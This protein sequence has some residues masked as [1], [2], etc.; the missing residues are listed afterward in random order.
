M[1]NITQNTF[2]CRN[3]VLTFC[4]SFPVIFFIAKVSASVTSFLLVRSYPS[5][6]HTQSALPCITAHSC[7]WHSSLSLSYHE[8][9]LQTTLRHIPSHSTVN[10]TDTSMRTSNFTVPVQAA[11]RTVQHPRPALGKQPNFC[12]LTFWHR[13]FTF[14][15]NKSP[16]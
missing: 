5:P 13:N 16:T 4:L 1:Q 10:F 9:P 2:V 6:T 11:V 7:Y 15:S 14:N 3:T 8:H 12:H